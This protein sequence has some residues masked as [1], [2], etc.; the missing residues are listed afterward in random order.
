MRTT[1]IICL[2]AL[3]FGAVSVGMA[4]LASCT[5]VPLPVFEEEVP[6]DW[7]RAAAEL[8][9]WPNP[10]WWQ[11]FGS[12]ELGE[13]IATLE[14]SNVDLR[15]SERT[16]RRAQLLLQDAGFD[17]LPV[18]IVDI[19]GD[20]RYSGAEPAGS[21]FSA[22]TS[23]SVN[24]SVG[25]SYT[26][27]LSKPL[28]YEGA[29][30]SYDASLAQA[31]DV[32]LNIYGTAASTYFRI[33]LLRDRIEAA[34]L[35]LQNAERIARI[36]QARVDAG[37]VPPIDALQQQ[38]AVQRQR[39]SLA[40][41]RQREFEARAALA[42]L[43]SSSAR[44]FDVRASTLG[45]LNTPEVAPGLPSE[46]LSR[47]PDLVRAEA[48]LRGARAN[49]E[50]A[51]RSLLPRISLTASANRGSDSLSDILSGANLAVSVTSG[52]VQQV[53]DADRRGREIERNQLAYESLID[54]YRRA[55]IRAFND[56]EV[57][58]GN[59]ELLESLGE[60]AQ[61]DLGRA[62]ESLRIAEVRYREGVTDYQTVLNSQDVLYGARNA[63]L[64]NKNS[65]LN[66]IISMYQALG[67]G[68]RMEYGE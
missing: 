37:V 63:V 59:I 26:D 18:P 43:L 42:L 55:I 61:E 62:T 47:R 67:G 33:L 6:N 41:L 65:H 64:E 60:V 4:L 14:N 57:A 24:L 30:A 36:V 68:W 12:E 25:I 46:L 5:S 48:A 13:I 9:K 40:S 35:N 1:A 52:L 27:I 8:D 53:F 56:I 17:L 2:R 66:A 20:V 28:R 29:E 16:L 49:L 31:A 32:R 44:D 23:E 7:Q 15:N 50:I 21:D 51:R 58:L 54:D 45:D 10:D 11:G 3:R 38:I 39:N 22:S 19:G 34:R